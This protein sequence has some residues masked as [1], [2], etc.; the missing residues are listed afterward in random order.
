MCSRI[1]ILTIREEGF[2]N[3]DSQDLINKS[4][5]P[6]LDLWR[7]PGTRILWNRLQGQRGGGGALSRLLIR[8]ATSLPPSQDVQQEEKFVTEIH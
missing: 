4:A 8:L 2:A 3:A 6:I 1:L 5:V 7:V